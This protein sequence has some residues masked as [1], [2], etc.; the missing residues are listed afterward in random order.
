MYPSYSYS[1]ANLQPQPISS[2]LKISQQEYYN[3]IW[4]TIFHLSSLELL[5]IWRNKII[6]FLH[7]CMFHDLIVSQ[8]FA[9]FQSFS[10]AF[11]VSVLFFCISDASASVVS[12]YDNL[13]CHMVIYRAVTIFRRQNDTGLVLVDAFS[14][15][16]SFSGIWSWTHCNSADPI[17]QLD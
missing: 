6:K 9:F 14:L 4:K 11:I 10:T 16:F 1:L 8:C 17:Y 15:F 7:C 13:V 12:Y 2:D 5:A 3:L